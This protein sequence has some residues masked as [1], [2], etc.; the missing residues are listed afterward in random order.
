MSGNLSI[1][2][3]LDT[4]GVATIGY[5]NTATGTNAIALGHSTNATGNYSFAS[6]KETKATS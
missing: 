2:G 1:L 3:N 6:G 4:S 5:G